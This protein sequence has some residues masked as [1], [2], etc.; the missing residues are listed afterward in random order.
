MHP[1]VVTHVTD[2]DQRLLQLAHTIIADD[3]LTV[4]GPPTA[5][6][7]PEGHVLLFALDQDGVPSEGRWVK[8]G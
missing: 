4:Q 3:R 7:M 6:H 8:V 5:A 1:G 2:T